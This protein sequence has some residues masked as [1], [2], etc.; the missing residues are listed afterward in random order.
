M[1][2]GKVHYSYKNDIVS[3]P[4]DPDK[5]PG[6][7]QQHHPSKSR[8]LARTAPGDGR[9]HD[10]RLS[11]P[12]KAPAAIPAKT[13]LISSRPSISAIDVENPADP[14][15]APTYKFSVTFTFV[16]PLGT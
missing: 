6:R 7:L 10:V 11:L 13:G 12:T 8:R 3:H 9:P 16:P 1:S 15:L 14:K 2:L 5:V 4:N